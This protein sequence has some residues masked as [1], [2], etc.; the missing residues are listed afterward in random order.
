MLYIYFCQISFARFDEIAI[1]IQ[2]FPLAKFN[3]VGESLFPLNFYR[4]L[5]HSMF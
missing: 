2:R 1:L 5:M 4:Q 3:I